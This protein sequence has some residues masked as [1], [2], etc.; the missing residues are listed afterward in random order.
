MLF[1]I[2][3]NKMLG[4]SR[5]LGH[6]PFTARTGIR[7]PYRVPFVVSFWKKPVSTWIMHSQWV[8]RLASAAN[9]VDVYKSEQSSAG[10]LV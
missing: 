10:D 7:I 6:R 2:E 3:A 4:S 8:L 9:T 1:N 5:G